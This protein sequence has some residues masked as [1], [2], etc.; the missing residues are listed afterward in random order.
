VMP[1]SASHSG[2]MWVTS[3]KTYSGVMSIVF[4]PAMK[5]GEPAI[6]APLHRR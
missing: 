4:L 3:L 1:F 5:I 6:Q 2:V